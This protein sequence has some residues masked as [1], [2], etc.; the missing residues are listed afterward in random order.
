MPCLI[1]IES[2]PRKEKSISS[3]IAAEFIQEYKKTHSN[4]TFKHIFL[5]DLDLP[6][7]DD[8][9][10]NAH[11]STIKGKTVDP[12]SLKLWKKTETLIEDFKSADKYLFSVPMWN[13]SIPYKLKHYI[14]LIVQEKYTYDFKDGEFH[15][16]ITGKP[17]ALIYARA[18]IYEEN[19]D[20]QKNYMEKILRFMG[21]ESF[22]SIFVEPNSHGEDFRQKALSLAKNI[23][24]DF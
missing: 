20:M 2:S 23:A 8:K 16:L 15:G 9:L 19:E 12:A 11:R 3:Q 6:D 18:D 13:F 1:H 4:D 10:I 14:D 7:L 21:F 17:A 5:W 22:I 24:K